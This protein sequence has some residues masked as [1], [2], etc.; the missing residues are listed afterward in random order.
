MA[1]ICISLITND[2]EYLFMCL[3]DI[4]TSSILKDFLKSFGSFVIEFVDFFPVEFCDFL[5][6]SRCWF[7]VGFVI[8]RYFLPVHHLS[9]I[10]LTSHSQNKRFIFFYFYKSH[11]IIFFLLWIVFLVISLKTFHLHIYTIHIQKF[12]LMYFSRSFTECV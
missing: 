7:S 6:Y 5:I 1:F 2:V 12:P 4:C 8:C 9:F 10:L 11:F 3:F